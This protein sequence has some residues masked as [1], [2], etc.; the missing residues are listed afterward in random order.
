MFIW[1][2]NALGGLGIGRKEHYGLEKL[3]KIYSL[4]ILV[5]EV[6]VDPIFWLFYVQ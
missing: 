2:T 6:D 1:Y 3:Y 4:S 5:L